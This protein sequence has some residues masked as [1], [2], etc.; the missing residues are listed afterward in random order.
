MCVCVCVCVCIYMHIYRQTET[1]KHSNWLTWAKSD[2]L[3]KIWKAK[4]KEADI[5]IY[6]DKYIDIAQLVKS[7]THSVF[8]CMYFKRLYF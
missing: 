1:E 2:N 6:M 4:V 7:C 8:I 3:H 5:R